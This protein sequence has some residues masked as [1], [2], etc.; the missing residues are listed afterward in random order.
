MVLW[1][2]MVLIGVFSVSCHDAPLQI[3][4]NDQKQDQNRLLNTGKSEIIL[5]GDTV[6][7]V[8]QKKKPIVPKVI[9]S[10][11][12]E[13]I[14]VMGEPMMQGGNEILD[15]AQINVPQKGFQD[16]LKHS[17]SVMTIIKGKVAIDRR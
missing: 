11:V 1:V 9:K 4:E 13:E 5:I 8:P 17:D 3:Q 15:D 7:N 6:Y 10:E 12:Y 16:S 14:H 2:M